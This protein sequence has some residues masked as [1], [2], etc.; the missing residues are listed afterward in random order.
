MKSRGVTSRWLIIG[1]ISL[2]AIG[3][4]ATGWAQAPAPPGGA[5]GS[6]TT[7]GVANGAKAVQHAE[8]KTPG[9]GGQK[10]AEEQFKN[11]QVLKG[12]LPIS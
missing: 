1:G 3:V 6:A 5:S 10:L 2:S 9:P 8:Q 11:I 12:I 4:L 7:S